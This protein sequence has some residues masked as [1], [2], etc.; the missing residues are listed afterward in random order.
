VI[1]E[2]DVASGQPIGSVIKGH[3]HSVNHAVFSPDYV[4]CVSAL[5]GGTDV[6]WSVNLTHYGIQLDGY[7]IFYTGLSIK[8]IKCLWSP[9]T[10]TLAFITQQH[11]VILIPFSVL[12][13]ESVFNVFF[14]L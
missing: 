2:C 4:T 9:D 3:S 5:A 11:H 7:Q 10:N 1:N 13:L 12:H 6:Q 8:P 14:E